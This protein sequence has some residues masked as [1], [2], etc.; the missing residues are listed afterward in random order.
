MKTYKLETKCKHNP[1]KA[2]SLE[3]IL[4]SDVTPLKAT[5]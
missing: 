1:S 5:L 3:T 4:S 2:S